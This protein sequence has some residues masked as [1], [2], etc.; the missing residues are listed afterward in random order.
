MWT[1]TDVCCD[2]E[3]GLPFLGPQLAHLSNRA[4]S[5]SQ[6]VGPGVQGQGLTERPCEGVSD[7]R[8]GGQGGGLRRV[9]GTDAAFEEGPQLG[10]R[11]K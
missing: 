6:D 9:T 1:A 3:R 7:R 11:E 2:L 10:G 4:R 8:R 5:I